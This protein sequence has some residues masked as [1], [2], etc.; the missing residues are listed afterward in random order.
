MHNGNPRRIRTDMA[1]EQIADRAEAIDGFDIKEETS[2]GFHI[3]RLTVTA[4]STHLPLPG[5]YITVTLGKLW[6]HPNDR[7]EAAE[8][9]LS[10]IMRELFESFSQKPRSVLV[11]C[12]G[13]RRITS[14]SIGPL[15]SEKIIV[16]RHLKSEFP[17]IYRSFGEIGLSLIT[18]G[19]VGDT[20]IETC[21]TVLSA[22]NTVSPDIVIA[23]DALAARDTDRLTA[24]VQISDAGIAP[25]SGIGNHRKALD[26]ETL[27]VPV[28]SIGI[29]T[30]VHS[31]TLVLD[32]LEKSETELNSPKLRRLLENENGFFVTPKDADTSVEFYAKTVAHAVNLTFFGIREL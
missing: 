31:S 18:P 21:E 24:S 11:V 27:G 15:C 20:G 25:G 4:A 3:H 1:I 22:V 12:L 9:L 17:E 30:V 29:P 5:S 2:S 28:I 13:N 23:V 7:I 6:L 10:D 16:T 19:V 8:K 14:D 32:L 26:R